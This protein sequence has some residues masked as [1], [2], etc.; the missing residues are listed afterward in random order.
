[1]SFTLLSVS[2]LVIMSLLIY[3]QMA[4]G[5]RQGL[6]KSAVNLSVMIV[7]AFF[8]A[9]VSSWLAELFLTPYTNY[10]TETILYDEIMKFIG[11][12][13]VVD[14]FVIKIVL[15]LLIYV[16]AFFVLRWL[17]SMCIKM[18]LKK[19]IKIENNKSNENNYH[20]EN[21]TFFVRNE[22]K[23]GA[24]IG[25]V[26]GFVLTVAIFMP[27]VGLLRTVN[28]AMTLTK[29]ITN[30]EKIEESEEF[31]LLDTCANDFSVQLLYACGGSTIYDV[32]TMVKI[33]GELTYVN[34]EMKIMRSID[35]S[36]TKG[37]FKGSYEVEPEK[38]LEVYSMLDSIDKSPFLRYFSVQI[39][40]NTSTRWLEHKS[41]AGLQR[42]PVGDFKEMK[43]IVDGVLTDLAE[44]T[45]QTYKE[46]I[47]TALVVI[48]MI[49]KEADT[50]TI[51]DCDTFMSK[52]E[53]TRILQKMDSELSKNTRMSSVGE[54]VV[55]ILMTRLTEEILNFEEHDNESR[56]RLFDD[57]AEAV[58]KTQGLTKGTR[59]LAISSYTASSFRTFG[60]N[61][62]N[63]VNTKI[64][65]RLS[66]RLSDVDV[67]ITDKEIVDMVFSE[68]MGNVSYVPPGDQNE[69]ENQ[70]ENNE[71]GEGQV[72]SDIPVEEYLPGGALWG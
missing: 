20:S 2:I 3:G 49:Q 24:L 44:T 35:F 9:L 28:D 71:F 8:A 36:G 23:L 62:P 19:L 29:N 12:L 13:S 40:K 38:L 52:L 67:Y 50:L 61:I 34:K 66:D 27:V 42:P 57:L 21:E 47:M 37:V 64:S 14:D 65:N 70:G 30:I 69:Q 26:S 11:D 7:C 58:N 15:S 72:G 17:V 22:K 25:A 18:I 46:D 43:D 33:D 39:I 41:Y 10:I 63:A 32:A 53:E 4:K 68:Y 16:P 5:H 59:V 1:M 60:V 45:P 54:E 48:D 55:D 6:T 51:R 31:A 56:K